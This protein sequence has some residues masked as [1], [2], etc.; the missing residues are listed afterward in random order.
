MAL[1][2]K[3]NGEFVITN[4][5]QAQSALIHM[6]A[7]KAE[8]DEIRKAEGLDEMEMDQ[9][10]LK[11]AVTRWAVAAGIDRIE[12]DDGVW[13]TMIAQNYDAHFIGTDADIPTTREEMFRLGILDDDGTV[14]R[15]I[16]PLRKII[17]R[18]FKKNPKMQKEIWNRVTKRVVVK[19]EVEEIVAEGI[20]TVDDIA[21]CFVEK[22]KTPY[23]RIYEGE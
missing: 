5:K 3:E 20:L 15:S 9:V 17:F 19:E 16:I 22:A 8:C 1:K 13:A 10:E 7:L 18:K 14:K 6:R 12:I 11:K 2:R 21:P 23:L 4:M